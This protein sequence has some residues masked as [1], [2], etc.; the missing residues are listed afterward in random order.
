M[1]TSAVHEFEQGA[2]L[3]TKLVEY[4]PYSENHALQKIIFLSTSFA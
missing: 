2:K 3:Y 1:M 4:F